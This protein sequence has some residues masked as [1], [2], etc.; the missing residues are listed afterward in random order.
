LDSL[1]AAERRRVLEF[2]AGNEHF[3]LNV[4]MAACKAAMDAARDVP[5]S[6]L[7]TVMAR[8]GTDFGI[9]VSGL[10]DQW[11]T[12]PAQTP[13]GLYFAGHSA[14]DASPDMGDSAI[15]ETGGIGG[16]AMAAAPDLVQFV[17]GSP[18][19]AIVHSQRMYEITAGESEADTLPILNF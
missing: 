2:A 17:G 18:H 19:D 9:Q 4:G 1:D 14:D 15:T 6:S 16:F 12:G 7:V 10:G 3:F 5:H 11:F 13:R 8:N